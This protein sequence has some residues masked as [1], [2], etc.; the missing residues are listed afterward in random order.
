MPPEVLFTIVVVLAAAIGVAAWRIWSR[1]RQHEALRKKNRARQDKVIALLDRVGEIITNPLLPDDEVE[2]RVE[3][4]HDELMALDEDG[5][6][7]PLVEDSRRF[8]AEELRKRHEAAAS[9]G[10][11]NHQDEHS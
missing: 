6:L 7:A 3:T 9:K 2:A 5:I 8:V 1:R 4:T 10:H 11:M